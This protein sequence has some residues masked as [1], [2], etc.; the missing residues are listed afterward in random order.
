MLAK[1][2]LVFGAAACFGIVYELLFIPF[3]LPAVVCGHMALAGFKKSGDASA[4]KGRAVAGLI[5]G[6]I[7]IA[8]TAL[9]VALYAA[10]TIEFRI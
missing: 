6:Y 5:L 4:G 7:L 2:S 10:G 1:A 3:A 8:G 9:F